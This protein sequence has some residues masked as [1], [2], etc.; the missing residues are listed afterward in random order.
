MEAA[1]ESTFKDIGKI[2]LSF[3][4]VS[5]ILQQASV[6]LRSLR[7]F[8]YS[9]R[10]LTPRQDFGELSRAAAGHALAPGSQCLSHTRDPRFT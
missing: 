2:G 10:S 6:N 7:L 1:H 8:R 4:P 5:K 9:H 3:Q